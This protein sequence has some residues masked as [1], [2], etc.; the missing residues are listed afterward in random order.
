MSKIFYPNPAVWRHAQKREAE[1]NEKIRE[2]LI[3]TKGVN[4]L[5]QEEAKF[6]IDRDY[7]SLRACPAISKL[8]KNGLNSLADLLEDGIAR[9]EAETEAKED[10][11]YE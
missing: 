3:L 4:R 8:R 1:R 10:V 2:L 6:I 9:H 5:T 7:F 11:F